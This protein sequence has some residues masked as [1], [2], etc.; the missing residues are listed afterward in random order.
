[1]GEC[2]VRHSSNIHEMRL[3]GNLLRE[4]REPTV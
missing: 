3:G 1:M 2:R 4:V